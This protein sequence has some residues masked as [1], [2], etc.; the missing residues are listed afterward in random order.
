MRDWRS[1]PT[2]AMC[3]AVADGADLASFSGG[4]YDVR[5][6]VAGI[7]PESRRDR[8]LDAVP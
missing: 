8:S 6:V 1:D 5:A 7:L 3:L 2:F 4:A